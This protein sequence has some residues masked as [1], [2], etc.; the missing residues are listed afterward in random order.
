MPTG[1]LDYSYY[2]PGCT[3]PGCAA[4]KLASIAGPENETLSFTYDGQLQTSANWSGLVSGR[5][6]W[7]YDNDFR[8]VTETVQGGTT[9]ATA[10]FGYDADSLLTCASPT[11]CPSGAGALSIT[12]NPQ[13]ALLVGTSLGTVTDSYTYNVYGE[14]ATYEAKYGANSLYSVTYDS[15]SAHRDALGRVVQK[16]ETLQGTTHVFGYTYDVQGRLTDVTRDGTTIE[17]YGYDPNGNRTAATVNGTT[18]N[19]TYDD[20]D[21][22]LTYGGTTFTYTANGELRT[23]TDSAGTTT[24]TYDA[25]GSL[26]AVSLPDGRLIEYVTDGKGRRIGKLV[27][28]VL[29]KQWLYRD[30]L[31][32]VAELDGSGNI[33]AE[34]IY[35]TKPNVP[36][37]VIRGGITYRIISDQLGSPVMA[38]N[39]ENSSDVAF[40][41]SYSAWGERTLVAGSDEWM[42]FGFA[43]GIYDPDT[44]L[45][46]FGARDYDPVIGRWVS[47]DPIRFKSHQVNFYVYVHNDPINRR[48]PAGMSSVAECEQICGDIAFDFEKQC[49]LL[50]VQSSSSPEQFGDCVDSCHQQAL[51]KGGQC[52]DICDTPPDDQ[53]VHCE[54]DSC[55]ACSGSFGTNGG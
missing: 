31:K 8:K 52:I 49:P 51:S 11:T 55:L 28:G 20:Q 32:P 36:D 39:T 12:R 38:V 1:A 47:K 17:H 19:P 43:G 26:I 13:N 2:P 16:T 21:R 53:R 18:V 50:C 4:G 24:Y 10:A 9:T 29:T 23:K 41:A 5:V 37:L 27:N 33:V 46:R 48:D 35:G 15:S 45:T 14:L 54:G 30:Q 34:F 25:M 7:T 3:T 42:V 22:L 6:S 44:K 40:V